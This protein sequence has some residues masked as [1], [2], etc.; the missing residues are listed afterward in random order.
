MYGYALKKGFIEKINDFFYISN[1]TEDFSFVYTPGIYIN[2]GKDRVT[3]LH[4][5]NL[6]KPLYLVPGSSSYLKN[7]TNKNN[8][9][10]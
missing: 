7:K 3:V 5:E 2:E 1:S 4:I 6:T 10:F 9:A 8:F